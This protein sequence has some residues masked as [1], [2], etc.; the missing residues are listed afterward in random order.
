MYSSDGISLNR[1]AT[2]Y[3]NLKVVPETCCLSMSSVGTLKERYQ[4]QFQSPSSANLGLRVTAICDSYVR[5]T[6]R[7]S[8]L[9]SGD[10]SDL[11]SV[12]QPP[13]VHWQPDRLFSEGSP[14]C[15]FPSLVEIKCAECTSELGSSVFEE[16]LVVEVDVSP[17][18]YFD[19]PRCLAALHEVDIKHKLVYLGLW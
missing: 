12:E 9:R 18:R 2:G 8:D 5:S 1:W 17:V 4:V 14:P 3:S 6:Y 11:V 16:V 13:R 10:V 19:V 7:S 15:V